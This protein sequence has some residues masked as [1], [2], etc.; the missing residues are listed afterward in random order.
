MIPPSP[1]RLTRSEAHAQTHARLLKAAAQVFSLRGFE[2]ASVDEIAE[3]AGFSRG[4]FYAHFARKDALFLAL[5]DQCLADEA[6]ALGEIFAR[7]KSLAA[8]LAAASRWT[9]SVLENLL[10]WRLLVTEFLLYAARHPEIQKEL[11]SRYLQQ[12]QIAARLLSQVYEEQ[13]RTP[14]AP[15]DL[16][17]EAVLALLH[18]LEMRRL[19]IPDAIPEHLPALALSLLLAGEVSLFEEGSAHGE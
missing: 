1:R 8:R 10:A 15:I 18:G 14:P 7:E 17:T 13:G 11:A 19:T 12:H 2:G 4:A 5:L 16:L 3:A 6:Q 9:P